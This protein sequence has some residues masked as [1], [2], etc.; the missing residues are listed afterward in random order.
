MPASFSRSRRE[1]SNLD[2]NWKSLG[3]LT[4]HGAAIEKDKVRR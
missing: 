2:R 3:E 1:V 4:H